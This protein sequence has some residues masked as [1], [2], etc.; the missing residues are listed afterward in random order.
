RF[1]M[2]RILSFSSHF[3]LFPS[4]IGILRDDFLMF[5]DLPYYL[6]QKDFPYC[7]SEDRTDD[8]LT[9]FFGQMSP[10]T[11]SGYEISYLF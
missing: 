1:T 5:S 9:Y 3:P 2:S 4:W 6:L 11:S 10:K 7:R 8:M